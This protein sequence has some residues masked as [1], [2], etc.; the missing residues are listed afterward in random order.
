[1]IFSTTI[2]DEELEKQPWFINKDNEEKIKIRENVIKNR[3]YLNKLLLPFFKMVDELIFDGKKCSYN[4]ELLKDI[5]SFGL[6]FKKK[7]EQVILCRH[8]NCTQQC[9][10]DCCFLGIK[11]S[12]ISRCVPENIIENMWLYPSDLH[13]FDIKTIR[14]LLKEN[15]LSYKDYLKTDYWQETRQLA[16]NRENGRCQLC[17]NKA[18]CLH[19]HHKTYEHL[20]YEEEFLSDLTVLCKSCH[21]KFHD[22]KQ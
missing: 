18:V 19:V 4:S 16:I 17:N 3:E 7:N 8:I 5:E 14:K 9:S 11:K 12:S 1:M 6:V 22:I 13:L 10:P 15:K 2:S 20:G 21:E